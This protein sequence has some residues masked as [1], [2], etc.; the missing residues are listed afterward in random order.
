[1][2]SE[3]GQEGRY[4]RFI[5]MY[6]KDDTDSIVRATARPES[7]PD[8]PREWSWVEASVWTDRM[9]TALGNGVRGGRWHSVI[10]KVYAPKTLR[11]AWRR[12]AA[13]RGA[14]GMPSSLSTG[15]SPYKKPLL[16]RVSPD[17]ETTNWRAVCG[18]TACTVRRAGR[19]RVLPDPYLGDTA[20]FLPLRN[21]AI[22]LPALEQ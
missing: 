11:A 6:V 13:N 20:G 17:K 8:D 19:M 16:W 7:V 15:F 3:V 21:P 5:L 12:V 1:M 10:D 9:L 18:K 2:P 14:A 22:F 4:E